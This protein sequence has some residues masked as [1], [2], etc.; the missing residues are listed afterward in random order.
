M[1]FVLVV[2]DDAAVRRLAQAILEDAGYEVATSAN[3]REALEATRR[4]SP[5]AIVLDL[6][7]PEVDGAAFYRAVSARDGAAPPTVILS[8]HE[9]RRAARELGAPSWLEK[10]FDEDDLLQRVHALTAHR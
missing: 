8:A 1:Q 5:D 6:Q 9:P 7:M 3:G 2:D 10:P 4:R